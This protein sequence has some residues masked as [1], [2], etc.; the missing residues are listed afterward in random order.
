MV[1]Q[2]ILLMRIPRWVS[3]GTSSLVIIKRF[4]QRSS[5]NSP[6]SCSDVSFISCLLL[7]VELRIVSLAGSGVTKVRLWD[8]AILLARSS[9]VQLFILYSKYLSNIRYT[10]HCFSRSD[11][12]FL[13]PCI[14]SRTVP[15]SGQ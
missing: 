7:F 11:K 2:S 3:S 6:N 1:D 8:H 5:I 4:V 12:Y 10:L 14:K 15:F 9:L 13:K